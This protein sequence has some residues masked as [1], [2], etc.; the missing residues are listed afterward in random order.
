MVFVSNVKAVYMYMINIFDN[1]FSSLI[2]SKY[3][4]HSPLFFKKFSG[5][6]FPELQRTTTFLCIDMSSNSPHLTSTAVL[7][8]PISCTDLWSHC[9]ESSNSSLC[10][11]ITHITCYVGQRLKTFILH[12]GFCLF[13]LSVSFVMSQSFT[14]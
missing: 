13:A 8:H 6:S 9:L 7:H 1:Y 10:F 2:A 11:Y 5:N 12:S 3:F 4:F 14:I